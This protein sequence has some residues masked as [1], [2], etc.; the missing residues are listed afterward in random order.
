MGGFDWKDQRGSDGTV[1]VRA[2]RSLCTANLPTLLPNLDA[3]IAD[4]IEL[5][6]EKL[7]SVKGL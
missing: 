3:G 1:F 7:D 2:L 5:E 4:Q 6:L